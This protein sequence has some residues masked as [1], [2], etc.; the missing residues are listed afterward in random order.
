LKVIV[1][2]PLPLDK[3]TPVPDIEKLP[4]RFI[5]GVPEPEFVFN[6][7]PV[8]IEKLPPITNV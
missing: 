7:Q 5:V 8:P 3:S 6:E 2:K 4:P 1:A